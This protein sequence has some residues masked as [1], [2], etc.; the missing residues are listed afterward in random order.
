MASMIAL[1]TTITP[2][3]HKT[4]LLGTAGEKSFF[5]SANLYVQNITKNFY[6]LGGH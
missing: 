6:G 4:L 1:L 5:S 2:T 3:A